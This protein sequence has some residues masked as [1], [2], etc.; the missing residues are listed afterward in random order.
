MPPSSY[1]IGVD[2]GGTYTDCAVIEAQGHRVRG[3]RQGDHHQGRPGHR[4][5]RG[6]QP[7]GGAAAGRPGAAGHRPG[8]GVDHAGHQCRGRRPWQRG[9]PWCWSASTTRMVERT[10]IAPAFP[11]VPV[12]RIAGG[13]D[14]NGDAGAAAGPG[15]AASRRWMRSPTRSRRLPWPRRSRCATRRMSRRC[16]MDRRAHRQAGDGVDRTVVGAR[17]AAPGAD[18]GAQCAADRPRVDADRRGAARHGA[19]CRSIAR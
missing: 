19:A 1:L 2:T 11:G 3:A 12:I 16:A 14:H 6:H 15:R 5:Q 4:R 7:G 9:R 10:G 8:V 13:H 17:R 18:R